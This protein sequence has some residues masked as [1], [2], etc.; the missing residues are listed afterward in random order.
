MASTRR[1]RGTVRA[2]GALAVAVLVTA[3]GGGDDVDLD[4]DGEGE[5]GGSTG[6]TLVAAISAQPD[7]F[8]PHKTQAHASFQVLE[9]VYDTLVVPDAEGEF[10]PS[11]ATDWEP[12]DDGLTWTFTLRD[13]VTFHDGS[14][15]DSADVVYS[16]NRI[17]NEDLANAYRFA[18]VDSVEAPDPHTVVINLTQP[19]PALLD[20]IGGFKGMSIL[21]E[22]AGEELDLATEAVGTG[23]FTFESSGAGGV[24]LAKNDDYWGDE[25]TVDGVEFQYISEPS[26]ALTAVQSGDVDWTDNVPPQEIS[27]LESSDDVELGITPSVDYWYLAMNQANAPFDN[28]DFRRAVAYGIDR[29][30]ITDAATFGAATSNQVAIP[31]DSIWYHEYAPFDHDPDQAQD[32]MASSGAA[33][34]QEMEIMVTDEYPETIQV[35]QVIQASLREIGVEVSVDQEDFGTWLDRQGQGDF[36][37][38]ILGWLGNLDPF[39]F[40][41]AQH[42]CEG[43]SN[44][45]G[46]CNP[47]VDDLLTQA[48]TETE[49]DARK[50]LY[51]QAAEII[52]DD[53][54]YVYLYNPD[55]VHAWAPGLE[56]YETRPDKALNFETVRLTE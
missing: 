13:D 33:T 11:L 12:S 27:N 15:F 31:E 14:E 18:S 43:T 22:G 32:L 37:A 24:T 4:G 20:N 53:V 23:P 6:G 2:A 54:S 28:R 30:A 36:D 44:F 46:Y 5:D 19:T 39:G 38:F 10:Q 9:N 49:H 52:A 8:D 26:A 50:A 48:A 42:V 25:P 3:C 45:Q 56:G 55:V 1:R 47:E 40:Y 7:Q 35:A 29:D 51:D 34:P 17:I 41:H 16:Y 21:P